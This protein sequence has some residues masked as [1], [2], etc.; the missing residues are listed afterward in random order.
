MQKKNPLWGGPNCGG[1]G[2]AAPFAPLLIRHCSTYTI[3]YVEHINLYSKYNIHKIHSN[4]NF[5]TR[6][7]CQTAA[8]PVIH[9]LS[10]LWLR[11]YH[12]PAILLAWRP[13]KLTLPLHVMSVLCS[14]V[15]HT[16]VCQLPHSAARP[17]P[18]T[19]PSPP[20]R[21]ASLANVHYYIGLLTAVCRSFVVVGASSGYG[22]ETAVLFARLGSQV[23]LTDRDEA[24][25]RRTAAECEQQP[26]AKQARGDSSELGL[27]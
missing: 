4:V 8:T 25:L 11:L 18:F 24:N 7:I 10:V 9:C 19:P 13:A 14:A 12:H 6:H 27:R 5:T 16:S 3:A 22:A 20:G 17:L 23:A 1:P 21:N 15:D 26:G 2:A